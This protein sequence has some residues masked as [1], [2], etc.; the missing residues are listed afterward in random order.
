MGLI[1][2]ESPIGKVLIGKKAGDRAEVDTPGGIT[3]LVIK[4]VT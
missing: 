2:T 3:S 4:E 1:S